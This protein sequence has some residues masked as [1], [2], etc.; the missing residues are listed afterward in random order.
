[1]CAR[2]VSTVAGLIDSSVGDLLVA[3]PFGDELEDFAL[4]LRQRVV[5]VDDALVGEVPHV[6]VEHDLG[7][8]GAE[9]R[10]A[11]GHV[12]DRA[13]QVGVG[14]ILQQVAP[15][16]GLQRLRDVRLVRVHAQDQDAHV[17]Q[18]A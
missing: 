14:G 4:A 18:R 12:G 7:D 3:V 13:D 17:R 16:A 10:L 1:M 5:A 9:E 11:G 2:C 8:R 6:V 15:R